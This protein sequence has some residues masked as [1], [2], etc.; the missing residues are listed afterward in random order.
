VAVSAVLFG[1][2][3]MFMSALLSIWSSDVFPESP[4]RGFSSALFVFGVGLTAGPASLGA[5]A[6]SFGL[7]VMF[8]VAAA[9]TALTALARPKGAKGGAPPPGAAG[10][11]TADAPVEG[12]KKPIGEARMR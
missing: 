11:R 8:L 6:A 10:R 2:G 1:T 12:T 9:V 4:S 5:L 7:E 3:V